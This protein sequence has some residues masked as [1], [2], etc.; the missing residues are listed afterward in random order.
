MAHVL[1]RGL[2]YLAQTTSVVVM[3]PNLE[4]GSCVHMFKRFPKILASWQALAKDVFEIDRAAGSTAGANRTPRRL[5]F[6]ESALAE[7]RTVMT[8]D[9]GAPKE[10][11]PFEG[12]GGL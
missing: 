1:M 8:T 7:V 4:R 3:H 5:Q 11:L 9:I 12:V 10:V 6:C 2:Q